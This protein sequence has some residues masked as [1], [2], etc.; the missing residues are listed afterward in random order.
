MK[1]IIMN[2]TDL[3]VSNISLGTANLGINDKPEEEYALLDAF[4]EAGGNFIDTARVYSDWVPGERGRSE[5]V[6][7]GWLKARGYPKDIVIATKGAHPEMEKMNISRLKKE[8]VEYDIKLSLKALGVEAID[9]YYL[10]RDDE[11]LSVEYI[12]DY[13]EDFKARGY[14]RYYACSNWSAQRIK[15]ALEYAEKKGYAGFSANEMMW[16]LA[17]AN[18][19]APGDATLRRMDENMYTL[20]EQ[21]KLCAVPY[22]SQAGGYFTK[23]HNAPYKAAKMP[24]H[25]EENMRR[26]K[27]LTGKFAD[28]KTPMQYVLGYFLGRSFGVIPVFA[29]RDMTQLKD[30]LYAAEHPLDPGIKL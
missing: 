3:R 12:L 10:H 27:E 23:I 8:D 13:L 5:R 1:K 29:A 14:L 19:N 17:S 30:T 21:T 25:T 6:L 2:N 20:H 26:A 28:A 16:N 24:Y 9:L 22:S 15:K 18:M 11:N 7:G 4:V